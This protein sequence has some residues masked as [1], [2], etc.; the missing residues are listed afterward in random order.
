VKVARIS[1]DKIHGDI[2]RAYGV[3]SIPT[4][5]LIR[6]GFMYNI[7]YTGQTAD[8]FVEFIESGWK[9]M[10]GSPIP[11][12]SIPPVRA[13]STQT[14]SQPI[15]TPTPIPSQRSI[16]NQSPQE[17]ISQFSSEEALLGLGMSTMLIGIGFFLGRMTAPTPVQSKQKRS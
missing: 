15:R 1:Q 4:L 16:W 6:N 7:T 14:P 8:E 12:V 11:V 17:I 3:T 2:L 9:D 5:K 13:A 10:Q